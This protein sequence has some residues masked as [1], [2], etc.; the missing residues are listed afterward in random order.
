VYELLLQSFPFPSIL[1]DVT[2]HLLSQAS[3]FIYS[4]R[5]KWVF[6]LLLWSF[7]PT[8]TFTSFP[9]PDCWACA[10]APAFSGPACLSTAHVGSGT[11]PLSCGAFLPP[12][13]LQAF[14]ILV[15]GHVAQ[16]LPSPAWLVYLQFCEGFPFPPLW[17]SGCPTLFAM[18]LYCCYYVLF[19]FSFFPR[20]RSVCS[21]SYA[22][23]A[24][25]CLWE[26]L[27]LLSSPCLHLPKLS[28]CR[29]LVAWGPSWFLC[30]T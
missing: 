20:W 29:Q 24:Q 15:A 26:Y 4:S 16:L 10:A 9:T 13:L 3:M 23:L 28:G 5:G 2:L 8:T 19:S 30:L 11:S 18:C 27:I 25:G 6:S 17:C 7:P 14:Q 22:D 21:G 1:G 12:P